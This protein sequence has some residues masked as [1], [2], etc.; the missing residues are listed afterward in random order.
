MVNSLQMSD[1]NFPL[2]ITNTSDSKMYISNETAISQLV[3][4]NKNY[5]NVISINGISPDGDLTNKNHIKI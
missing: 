2:I 1:N 4:F 3:V 5:L